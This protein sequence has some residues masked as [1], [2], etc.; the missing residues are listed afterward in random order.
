MV[1]GRG[2]DMKV[3][4]EKT[5][6]SGE[7]IRFICAPA[8]WKGDGP[9]NPEQSIKGELAVVTAGPFSDSHGWGGIF[10]VVLCKDSTRF[11]HWGDF[12]EVAV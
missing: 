9:R 11:Q 10:D 7:L 12:M 5:F 2:S 4:D 8:R 1:E 3:N 6:Q